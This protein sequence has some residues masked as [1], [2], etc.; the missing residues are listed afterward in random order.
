MK[1]RKIKK[2]RIRK[3]FHIKNRGKSIED[4]PIRHFI[5]QHSQ[6]FDI[7]FSKI[8]IPAFLICLKK[9]KKKPKIKKTKPASFINIFSHVRLPEY[10]INT[11][12][13]TTEN[14]KQ[15][16]GDVSSLFGD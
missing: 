9:N 11:L 12:N 1:Y 2:R 14:K 16:F 5:L 6:K 13:E 7:D 8:K 15:K 3:K 10:S 4:E